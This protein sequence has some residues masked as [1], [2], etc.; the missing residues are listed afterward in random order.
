[1]FNYILAVAFFDLVHLFIYFIGGGVV[2]LPRSSNSLECTNVKVVP[3]SG[4]GIF[5][6][7]S[8]GL[9]FLHTASLLMWC[10]FMWL[11]SLQLT[12]ASP[13]NATVNLKRL[14]DLQPRREPCHITAWEED[15]CEKWHLGVFRWCR[16]GVVY[17][18][19]SAN[20]VRICLLAPKWLVW[21]QNAISFQSGLQQ[22]ESS[23]FSALWNTNPLF[24]SSK[25]FCLVFIGWTNAIK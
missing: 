11:R 13:V 24:M 2:C 18:L 3:A 22:R 17:I 5:A 4:D 23:T 7:Q 25:T 19:N 1:M 21:W 20:V 15:N 10:W 8:P 9:F 14:A 12:T 16:P 6:S